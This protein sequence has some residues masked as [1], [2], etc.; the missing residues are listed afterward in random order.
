MAMAPSGS[1][2]LRRDASDACIGVADPNKL[3]Q[4]ILLRALFLLLN[5]PAT[6][7]VSVGEGEGTAARRGL[8]ARECAGVKAA[9]CAKECYD[10][11]QAAATGIEMLAAAASARKSTFNSRSYIARL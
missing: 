4:R 11:G 8:A 7:L 2:S 1:Q 10:A 9:V 3:R 6:L 5:P